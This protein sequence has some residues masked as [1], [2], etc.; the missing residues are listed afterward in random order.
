MSLALPTKP[1][2]ATVP[3]A[4]FIAPC[5]GV[6]LLSFI[7]AGYLPIGFSIATVFLFAGPHNWL[8]AR[9]MLTRMP[10][11]WGPLA[12]YFTLGL[13]GVGLLCGSIWSLP[14]WAEGFAWGNETWLTALAS[15][16][17]AVVVWIVALILVRSRQ[18]PERDWN[19]TVPAGLAVIAAIWQWPLIFSVALVYLHPCVALWFL[20]RELG[21]LHSPWRTAY[22]W[23][24][25]GVPVCLVALS[26]QL[27]AAPD[28]PGD[29][30]VR[31]AI[32]IHAGAGIL[33]GVSTHCLVACH[34]FLEMLHYGVWVVAIPLLSVK[35]LP[36]R[37]DGIPLARRSPLW[38]TGLQA[39]LLTGLVVVFVLWG[40]FWADYP[41]TRYIYFTLAMVHVLAEIPFLLRLL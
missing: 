32:T 40:A 20:D 25:L 38:Q 29:D 24:L 36:W 30:A 27:A 4:W 31:E 28:L 17:S 10:A 21:R 15:W 2:T 11:K 6:M 26:I 8:E 22:R 9:Y 33:S 34:T 41:L 23:C 39:L 19:W 3:V 13:G 37:T 12:G 35:Q 5:A 16:Y 7:L 1:T 14:W 18:N